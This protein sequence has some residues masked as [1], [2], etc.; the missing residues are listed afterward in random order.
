MDFHGGTCLRLC[1][2]ASRHSEDLGFVGSN[3]FDSTDMKNL[4]SA[5]TDHL[6][7][8]YGLEVTV[9]SPKDRKKAEESARICVD[10]WLISIVTR[11]R[12]PD[13]PRQRIKLEI[14]NVT[15][16]TNSCTLM[17]NY[18]F[19]PNEYCEFDLHAESMDEILAD[20]LV[21]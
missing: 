11:P 17:R 21:A 19:L 16:T 5:L 18:E 8:K 14:A 10:K 9:K 1:Y 7:E 3:N 4:A 15:C 12:R 13:L 6:N 2:N 20:K